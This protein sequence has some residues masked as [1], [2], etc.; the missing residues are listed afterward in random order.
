[1]L[2][3]HCL[4]GQKKPVQVFRF[5]TEGTVEEKII[6]RADRK[7]FL[8]AAVIQQGRLAEQH[9]SL[10]KGELMKMV[11]FGADQILSGKGG[12]YTDEDID[13]LIAKG[14]EKTSAMQ[15]KLQTDAQHNLANFSLLADDDTGRDTFSFD[16]KNYRDANKNAGNFITLPQRQRKRNYDLQEKSGTGQPAGMKAHAADAGARKKR[17]GPAL[18]DFQ[19]FDMER[20]N[21]IVVK[22]RALSATK[23]HHLRTITDLR[24]RAAV[25]PALGSGVAPGNSQE[26]LL[27]AAALLEKDLDSIRLSESEEEEKTNLLEEG[28]P[29]WSRKDFKSFCA[30]LEKHG[31]YDFASMYRDVASETGKDRKEIQRYFVAFWTHY[32]RIGEWPKIIEKIERREKKILRLRQVRDAIQEKIERHLEDTFGPHFG[33]GAGED[34]QNQKP[35]SVAEMLHHSWPRMK[36]NYGSSSRGKGYQEEEDAFLTCMMYRHGFGAAERIRMEIRRAWQFRFNWYFKSRSAQDIQKRCEALVKII[37]RENEEL[38]KKEAED[39]SKKEASP[40]DA[41]AVAGNAAIEV[42][43]AEDYD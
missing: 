21:A 14:E 36:I 43:L 23:E 17:K 39:D 3:N 25:A 13:A 33:D 20:L 42:D 41:R 28:F 1:M 26:E 9:S 19:L 16:G 22:E 29:D 34:G 38:R 24:A 5:V 11:R 12:T 37:E 31:R 18:H 8:D 7:L 32:Q 2:S 27:E 6:E 35:P 10:E 4:A 30:S 40:V 15:A